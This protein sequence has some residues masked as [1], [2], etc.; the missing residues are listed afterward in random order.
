MCI[1][2]SIDEYDNC[3][4]L[5]QVKSGTYI[6]L[7]NYSLGNINSLHSEWSTF[8]ANF[9]SVSTK[10]LQHYLDRFSF[11]KFINYTARV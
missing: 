8:L 9:R 11:Q 4:K 6:N 10:H 5:E 7:N 3:I 2:S 1:T